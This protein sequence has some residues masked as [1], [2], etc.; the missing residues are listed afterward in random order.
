MRGDSFPIAFPPDVFAVRFFRS[1][2]RWENNLMC[3]W[4]LSVISLLVLSELEIFWILLVLIHGTSHRL[5]EIFCQ[6]LQWG[7]CIYSYPDEC[8]VCRINRVVKI[9]NIV[10][11]LPVHKSSNRV[12]C[13]TI[14]RNDGRQQLYRSRTIGIDNFTIWT[15][16]A[17][18]DD[19][20]WKNEN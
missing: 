6:Q 9:K 7:L 20:G 18:G 19:S 11:V 3:I 8:A 5:E 16:T 4:I 10:G 14:T 13:T 1:L 17:H 12:A 15:D 2:W